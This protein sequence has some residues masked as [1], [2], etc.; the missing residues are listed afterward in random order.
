MG[1]VIGNEGR[2]KGRQRGDEREE[3]WGGGRELGE[4]EKETEE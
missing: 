3:E 4:G 1:R 2:I